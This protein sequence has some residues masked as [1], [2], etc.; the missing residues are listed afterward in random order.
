VKVPF[1][2][3]VNQGKASFVSIAKISLLHLNDYVHSELSPIE[4]NVV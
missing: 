2:L 1:K 4:V 3:P